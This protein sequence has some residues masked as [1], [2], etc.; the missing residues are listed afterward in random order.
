MLAVYI[1]GIVQPTGL[2]AVVVVIV[3]VVVVMVVVIVV[4]IRIEAVYHKIAP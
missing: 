2:L 1:V 3:V 4:V